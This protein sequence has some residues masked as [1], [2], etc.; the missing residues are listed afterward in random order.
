MK[1]QVIC[2]ADPKEDWVKQAIATYEKK[3]SPYTQFQLHMLKPIKLARQDAR[4]K[5]EKE[6]ELIL[7]KLPKEAKVILCD[8]RGKDL[9]SEQWAQRIEAHQ[10]GGAGKPL[11]FVIGG[12]YGFTKEFRQLGHECFKLSSL[13][14]NHQVALV[15]LLEQIYRSFN[16]IQ[17]TPYHNS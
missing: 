12:A 13:V 4:V 5:Q 9:S 14:M 1:I 2:V 17:R 3:L 16:I 6:T 7:K 10:E 15:V 11:I 8:E